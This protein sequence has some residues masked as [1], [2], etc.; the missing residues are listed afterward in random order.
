[1]VFISAA[2]V[3]SPYRTQVS[4]RRSVGSFAPLAC[5]MK[6]RRRPR[7][8]PK[9]PAS[10]TT[11]S[12]GEAWPE[13]AE[14]EAGLAAVQSSRA[15]TNAAKSTSCVSSTRR[16]RVVVPGLKESSR[17]RHARRLRGRASAPAPASFALP[18]NPGKCVACSSVLPP[19]VG[20]RPG[21]HGGSTTPNAQ[22][23]HGTDPAEAES[24][25]YS[26]RAVTSIPVEHSTN[27]LPARLEFRLP[28]IATL[29]T[30]RTVAS[31]READT[32]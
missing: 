21:H 31:G 20:R 23:E 13:P 10:K 26:S 16:V 1:M 4:P 32:F 24:K 14:G 17:D 27:R 28:H 18:T 8:L 9:R 12:R 3:A 7:T 25:A 2:F 30:G 6:V 22:A 29:H 19:Q 5:R 15:N 11:L